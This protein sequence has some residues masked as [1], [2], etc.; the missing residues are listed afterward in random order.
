MHLYMGHTR[1]AKGAVTGA[2]WGWR[3]AEGVVK[4]VPQGDGKGKGSTY[5]AGLGG[6]E[7]PGAVL[8]WRCWEPAGKGL[9]GVNK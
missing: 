1:S 7:Q 3:S 2:T 5:R 8:G 6:C 9:D 4:A